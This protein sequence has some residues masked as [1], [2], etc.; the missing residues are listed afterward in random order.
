ML[1][2][3][4]RCDF[5]NS[6]VFRLDAPHIRRS[7]VRGLVQF[8][9]AKR[10][11]LNHQIG[12][13]VTR[14][15]CIILHRS[16]VASQCTKVL[17]LNG[18]SDK[19]IVELRCGIA[20]I[21]TRLDQ[22]DLNH[23]PVNRS[24]RCVVN[25][26][27]Q[28]RIGRA[29]GQTEP[30]ARVSNVVCKPLRCIVIRTCETQHIVVIRCDVVRHSVN[31]HEVGRTV[32]RGYGHV[33]STAACAI[34]STRNVIS[35]HDHTLADITSTIRRRNRVEHLQGRARRVIVNHTKSTRAVTEEEV[36]LL[37]VKGFRGVLDDTRDCVL[38]CFVRRKVFN[39]ARKFERC[40]LRPIVD[41][42]AV[43]D[44]CPG[45]RECPT[46]SSLR[47]IRFVILKVDGENSSE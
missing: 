15:L 45:C 19:H 31:R 37:R 32:H 8:H 14:K 40:E 2:K 16:R 42:C 29:A 26:R 36:I 28:A 44:Q 13:L 39:I 43:I 23:I 1:I 12:F 38:E 20:T 24:T 33:R 18:C 34:R 22:S 21:V 30:R 47:T 46:L 5:F 6:P 7:T 27:V 25:D 11:V 41:R 4:T 9:T 35:I 3:L 10:H 17:V